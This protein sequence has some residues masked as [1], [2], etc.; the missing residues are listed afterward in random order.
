VLPVI[1]LV[2]FLLYL[3]C[4]IRR[5]ACEADAFD[6]CIS[7]INDGAAAVIL[8]S[9]E[10]AA[11]RGLKPLARIVASATAGIDPAIMGMGET[12]I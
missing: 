8:M 12:Q 6:L 11:R 7:G 10:E 3:T 2:F 5:N 4:L 1:I 9:V